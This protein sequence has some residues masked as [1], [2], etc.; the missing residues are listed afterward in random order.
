MPT[1]ILRVYRFARLVGH[2]AYT[3]TLFAVRVTFGTRAT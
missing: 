2:D 1:P 3:A